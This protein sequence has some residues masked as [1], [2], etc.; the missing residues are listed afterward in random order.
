[1]S[2]RQ[3]QNILVSIIIY[4]LHNNNLNILLII[5]NNN[6]SKTMSDIDSD[7]S[8]STGRSELEATFRHRSRFT[9]GVRWA[10]GVRWR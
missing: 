7:D 10:E 2:S 3:R 9:V 4:L 5:N 1:M 6:N 8:H